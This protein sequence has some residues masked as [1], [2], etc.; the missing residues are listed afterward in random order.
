MLASSPRL[1]H[2]LSRPA[3]LF[4]TALQQATSGGLEALQQ[5]MSV[6]FPKDQH[7][8]QVHDALQ[9]ESEHNFKQLFEAFEILDE[10]N[11]AKLSP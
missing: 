11:H 7:A 6:R 4:A 1:S 8:Q 2:L 10:R 9:A 5:A 3:N